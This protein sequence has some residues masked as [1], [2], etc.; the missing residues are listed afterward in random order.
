MQYVATLIHEAWEHRR[1]RRRALGIAGLAALLVA[2]LVIALSSHGSG[3]TSGGSA[4][5]PSANVVRSSTVLSRS[6]YLGVSCRVPNS[7]ACDRVGLAVWLKHPAASVTARINGAALPLDSYGAAAVDARVPRRQFT[8]FLQ[9]AG[10]V[11]RFHVRPVNGN[12]VT[13]SHGQ[14]QVR[15]SHQMWFGE[16]NARSPLIQ[17]TIHTST[18]K[19]L[20][21]HLR[22]GLA[23]G[24]G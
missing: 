7:I 5:P 16:S 3:S 19:T 4:P 23:A 22:V 24:W 20:T 17:L 6:P 11:S 12:V 2:A 21:T 10:I 15:V 9:P 18:G 14:T 13:P 8:G 1:R